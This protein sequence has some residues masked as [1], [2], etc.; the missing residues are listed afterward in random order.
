MD[1]A[2]T[3][4]STDY[5]RVMIYAPTGVDLPDTIEV[6]RGGKVVPFF[7]LSDRSLTCEKVAGVSGECGRFDCHRR[8]L[9]SC[10]CGRHPSPVKFSKI[11]AA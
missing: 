9:G 3:F 6:K 5:V 4:A 11:K 1:T 2:Y 7:R 8:A 10:Q